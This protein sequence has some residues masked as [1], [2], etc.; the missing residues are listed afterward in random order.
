M[1]QS[2]PTRTISEHEAKTLV[3]RREDQ[4]TDV[5]NKAITPIK[6]SRSISAFANTDGGDLY[7][8][9]EEDGR[10]RRRK[11]SGFPNEEAANGHVQ[12]LNRLFPL[13]TDFQYEFIQADGFDGLVLHI[14]VNKTSKVVKASGNFAYKRLGAQNLPCETDEDIRSLEYAKGVYSYELELT[15]FPTY[16]LTSS[17]VM[18]HFLKA[19]A[20]DADPEEWLIKQGLL[21]NEKPTVAGMLL[22]CDEPQSFLPKHCGIKISR[23]RTTRDVGDRATEVGMPITI[24]GCLYD[25]IREAVRETTEIVESVPRLGETS[26]EP[27]TYPQITLHEIIT[28]AILHRDYS[29]ANDVHIRVFDNR[30]EVQSPGKLPFGVTVA[31][32]LQQRH[33]RNGAINRFLNK[34]PNPP[35]RDVGEG[36]RAAFKAMHELNLK[37]PVIV[38]NEDSVLVLIRHEALGSAPEM[39]LEYLDTNASIRNFQARRLTNIDSEYKIRKIFHDLETAGLIEQVPGTS[40]SSSAWRK[41]LEPEPEM[42]LVPE[43]PPNIVQEETGQLR[44]RWDDEVRTE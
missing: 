15:N 39:I 34:F 23:Y 19:N 17:K 44:V 18:A 16:F 12:Q 30:V 7:I 11:W 35:N 29:I 31:R 33:A 10:Q 41:R 42:P 24:E 22:F 26:L 3:N 37:E 4:F 1:L 28:N 14:L 21:I 25:Q 36:L 32:I 6:L 40:T 38:E 27:V 20:P 2:Q 43:L 13:G 8:G 5:K 9:I